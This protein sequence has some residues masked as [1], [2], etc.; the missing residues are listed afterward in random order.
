[1]GKL[2]NLPEW[3]EGLS[4]TLLHRKTGIVNVTSVVPTKVYKMCLSKASRPKELMNAPRYMDK[5]EWKFESL[6][7]LYRPIL[8]HIYRPYVHNVPEHDLKNMVCSKILQP[9]SHALDETDALYFFDTSR[10]LQQHDAVTHGAELCMFMQQDGFCH[11][12]DCCKFSHAMPV[13][14]NP[15]VPVYVAYMH[16]QCRSSICTLLKL[17]LP[18]RIPFLRNRV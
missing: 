4:C 2:E 8:S 12:G 11:K 7:R 10:F 17:P 13:H 14:F 9:G 5:S 3:L 15:E 18:D 1:M 6:D 16:E